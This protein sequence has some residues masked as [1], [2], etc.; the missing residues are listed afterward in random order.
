MFTAFVF[1]KKDSFNLGYNLIIICIKDVIVGVDMKYIVLLRGINISGKNKILMSELKFELEC[2]KY[3][4][5]ITYI[6]SGNIILDSNDNRYVVQDDI[7]K[8]IKT[9]FKL[10]IPICVI[11]YG[12]L[13]DI[14]SNYPNWNIDGKK[15][16]NNIIFTIPPTDINEV[17][18]ALG[19]P[20][21]EID[22]AKC[23][24]NVIYWSYDLSNYR[25]SKWWVR[26]ASTS[27][28]DKITIRTV[29]TMK[30]ILE[31]CKK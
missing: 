5:V 18:D 17:C 28:R 4:D 30:H 19:D 24:K 10:D 27:I 9:K 20:D 29:N 31:L 16:Y 26:S 7:S 15:M 11:T 22:F 14:F 21:K 12:E 6:N 1:G 2:M 3:K 8:M 23:Y 25:K 13:L